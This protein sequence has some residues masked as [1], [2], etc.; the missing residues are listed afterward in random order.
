MNWSLFQ[1]DQGFATWCKDRL[2]PP[3]APTPWAK[4]I[5]SRKWMIRACFGHNKEQSS[6]QWYT[7]VHYDYQ[8][9]SQQWAAVFSY[10]TLIK[11]RCETSSTLI[12]RQRSM[13]DDVNVDPKGVCS[14]IIMICISHLSPFTT[15]TELRVNKIMW[16]TLTCA[17]N[18]QWD[19]ADFL[20]FPPHLITVHGRYLHAQ[21]ST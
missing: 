4:R 6:V 5:S 18:S 11:S 8:P 21:D 14:W 9:I 13:V 20:L 15:W 10:R 2:Q 3:P 7:C 19:P 16:L 17:W 1:G 12:R